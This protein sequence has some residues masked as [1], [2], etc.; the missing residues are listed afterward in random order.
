MESDAQNWLEREDEIARPERQERLRW[1]VEHYPPA[2]GFML[3]GGW[4]SKQLL[5]EAKYSF[6]YGQYVATATLG[7]AFVERI[8]AS[9]FYAA[10]RDD[11]ERAGGHELLAEAL[12][13]GWL[14]Q[15]DFD[16]FDRMRGLRNPL[17]HFRRP[18]A[19][20]TIEARAMVSDAHPDQ[21]VE[22][23]ARE[24]L[25]GVLRVLKK[26]AV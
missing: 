4:L 21:I 5:E 22:A 17:V 13:C 20:D 6:V 24:V 18:L 19:R 15:A 8:L 26:V 25:E 9:Q 16:R 23:D 2:E 12:R 14:T 1:I 7:V 11:L 10:G 3:W